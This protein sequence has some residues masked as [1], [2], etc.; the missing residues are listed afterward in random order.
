MNREELV[1]AWNK[2]AEHDEPR[3]AECDECFYGYHED[4]IRNRPLW[5]RR[6]RSCGCKVPHE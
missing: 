3:G 5:G 4:C 2:A 6:F 1:K